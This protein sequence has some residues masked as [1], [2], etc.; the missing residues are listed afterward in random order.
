MEKNLQNFHGESVH[1]PNVCVE[2]E[3]IH[4]FPVLAMF[5]D[6]LGHDYPVQYAMH[7][8][9]IRIRLHQKW[10]PIKL[11]RSIIILQHFIHILL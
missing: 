1:P 9:I 10:G 5:L 4:I 7:S 8:R 11:H 3:I 2:D 6:G